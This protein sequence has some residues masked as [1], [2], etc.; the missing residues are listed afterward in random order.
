MQFR[1]TELQVMDRQQTFHR[2][3]SVPPV[4]EPESARNARVVQPLVS[5]VGDPC[6]RPAA[7]VEAVVDRPVP[8]VAAAVWMLPAEPA[9][10]IVEAVVEI[11]ASSAVEAVVSPVVFVMARV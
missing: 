1:K 2:R 4:T 7:L 10:D 5:V 8:D 6:G 11:P 3:Q 9:A